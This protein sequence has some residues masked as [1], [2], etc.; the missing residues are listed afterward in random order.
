M[1]VILKLG[2]SVVTHKDRDEP[3][4]NKDA[5]RRAAKEIAH[6]LNVKKI[7]LIIVHG[8][9]SFGHPI[10]KRNRL[11]KGIK[12]V[13]QLLD[14]SITQNLQNRLNEL[15]CNELTSEKINAFCFQA[16]TTAV[17][18]NGRLESMDLTVLERLVSSA[19]IPVL[20]GTPAYDKNQGASILSG[21]EI[22][23]YL[24]KN[25]QV[26]LLLFATDV[27]GIY[28]SDPKKGKGAKLLPC[29][30]ADTHIGI[31]KSSNADVTGGML[32]KVERIAKAGCRALI[33]SGLAPGNIEDAL[34]GRKVG[35][36]LKPAAKK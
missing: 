9:G 8:A 18:E 13:E 34:L 21:D 30:S 23:L 12:N 15:V 16:S 10:V 29:I 5:A 3:S 1:R 33:F 24:V 14:F 36:I 2:G 26:D 20:F 22:I 17:M 27:D 6:A 4:F 28:D 7:E 32:G 19:I 25:M 35:T 11:N 31:G